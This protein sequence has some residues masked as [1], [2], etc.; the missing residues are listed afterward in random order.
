M[1]LLR[2]TEVDLLVR[3]RRSLILWG[4]ALM[5]T[6]IAL[7]RGWGFGL[8]TGFML[9]SLGIYCYAFRNWRSEPG[10]WMLA[11]FLT[12]VL[13]PCWAY[14][15]YLHWQHMFAPGFANNLKGG[16]AWNTIRLSTDAMISLLLFAKTVRLS[17]TVAIQNWKRTRKVAQTPIA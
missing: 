10:V 17:T 14:F 9:A 16:Q 2:E 1:L 15:E 7:P 11:G 12:V 8:F 4:T 6:A 13:A 3:N 5:A